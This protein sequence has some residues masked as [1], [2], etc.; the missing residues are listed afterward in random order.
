[1]LE[2]TQERH[3]LGLH[4]G[5]PARPRLVDDLV[6]PAGQLSAEREHREGVA[7]LAEGAEEEA[8]A[9]GQARARR[10]AAARQAA[11]SATARSCSI[12][13]GAWK[14][15]GETMSVPTPAARNAATRS[16]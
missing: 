13:S 8:Q 4:V 14:A 12:R 10:S 16:R 7:R 3:P 11:S 5:A 15:M 2:G 6:P 1:M 9:A